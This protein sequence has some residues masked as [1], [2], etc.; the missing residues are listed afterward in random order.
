MLTRPILQYPKG[1][2]PSKKMSHPTNKKRKSL[3][4]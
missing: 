1:P 2:A 4:R 3:R